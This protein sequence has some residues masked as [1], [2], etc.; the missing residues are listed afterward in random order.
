MSVRCSFLAGALLPKPLLV[1]FLGRWVLRRARR[2]DARRAEGAGARAR[3]RGEK[4]ELLE[5][6]KRD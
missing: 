1:L 3:L 6:K 4:S 5:Q 2:A